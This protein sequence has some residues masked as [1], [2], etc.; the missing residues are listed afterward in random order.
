M[1]VVTI[2]SW[3]NF[4]RPATR[5]WVCGGAKKFG[6]TLLRPARSVCFSPSAKFILICD[7]IL[8][9]TVLGHIL[10]GWTF[11][12]L[13]YWLPSVTTYYQFRTAI[14]Y[15]WQH[16]DILKNHNV[17]CNLPSCTIAAHCD[18]STVMYH[19]EWLPWMITS[20][21]GLLQIRLEEWLLC[22]AYYS[23]DLKIDYGVLIHCVLIHPEDYV[24]RESVHKDVRRGNKQTVYHMIEEIYRLKFVY[25]KLTVQEQQWWR[26]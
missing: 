3:L 20:V 12:Y 21:L 26:M 7:L 5:E 13:C 6:S 22:S 8:C 4:G 15:F 10:T 25:A 19:R 17:N 18:W 11:L 24:C 14:E 2:F 1:Q 16:S 23:D 9:V